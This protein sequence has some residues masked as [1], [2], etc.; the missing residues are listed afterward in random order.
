MFVDISIKNATAYKFFT[1]FHSSLAPSYVPR[2]RHTEANKKWKNS[3]HTLLNYSICCVDAIRKALRIIYIKSFGER[4]IWTQLSRPSRFGEGA[5]SGNM[6]SVK[7]IFDPQYFFAFVSADQ[8]NNFFMPTDHLLWCLWHFRDETL[9]SGWTPA[10]KLIQLNSLSS[11]VNK[12][13]FLSYGGAL[14]RGVEC[15]LLLSLQ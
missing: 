3:I 8:M 13:F 10:E 7:Y 6:N 12:M 5:K 4:N 15:N 9:P 14:N 1:F 2:R 11:R